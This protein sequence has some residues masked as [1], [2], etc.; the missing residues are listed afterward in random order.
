[1]FDTMIRFL[2]AGKDERCNDEGACFR[3]KINHALLHN[4]DINYAALHVYNEA[5]KSHGEVHDGFKT[6]RLKEIFY[7]T[8]DGGDDASP[9]RSHI[10]SIDVEENGHGS[11]VSG[12]NMNNPD[13]FRDTESTG[14]SDST[15]KEK[16]AR[17][18]EN[19]NG[20]Y[21]RKVAYLISNHFLGLLCLYM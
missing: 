12:A 17:E 16:T 19:E 9:E 21:K 3:F 7:N 8:T 10:Q 6:I 5:A 18:D 4:Y 20:G 14:G 11:D 2:C 1:M 13:N 15:E